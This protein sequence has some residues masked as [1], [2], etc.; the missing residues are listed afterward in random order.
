M[1]IEDIELIPEHIGRAVLYVPQHANG[2]ASHPDVEHGRIKRW[3]D[4][5]NAVFCWYGIGDTAAA[6][7]PDDLRWGT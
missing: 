4:G 3:D 1:K 7:N 6:T 2:D 5:V